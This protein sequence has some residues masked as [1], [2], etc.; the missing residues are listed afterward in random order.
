VFAA[1]FVKQGV[2]ANTIVPGF[3]DTEMVRDEAEL[4]A[5]A[6]GVGRDEVIKRFLRIQP[7]GRMVT[8]D[9][10]GAL[11]SFLCSDAAAPITGQAINID[12]GAHQS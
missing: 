2:T 11:V 5:Q 9:E 10:V 8:V 1:E 7:L 12:G 4:A 3:V 6:R